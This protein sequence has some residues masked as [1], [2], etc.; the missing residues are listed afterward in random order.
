MNVFFS[1]FVS[2]RCVQSNVFGPPYCCDYQT[3]YFRG[4]GGGG[5]LTCLYGLFDLWPWVVSHISSVATGRIKEPV[6]HH[7]LQSLSPSEGDRFWGG[8]C[9]VRVWGGGGGAGG[10]L[11]L[12]G[13]VNTECLRSGDTWK[14]NDWRVVGLSSI[15]WHTPPTRPHRQGHQIYVFIHCCG[16]AQRTGRSW[17]R[18]LMGCWMGRIEICGEGVLGRRQL[19]GVRRDWMAGDGNLYEL[20]DIWRARILE[21]H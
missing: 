8:R 10:T 3:L 13:C 15:C 4:V 2:W 7:H 18:W 14:G 9:A 12:D 17:R 11:C 19:K 1:F 6:W 16:R 20:K 21:I 5:Q